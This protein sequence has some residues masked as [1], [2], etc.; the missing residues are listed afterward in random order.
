MGGIGKTELAIQYC[1]KHLEQKTYPGGICWLNAREQNISSQIIDF[2]QTKLNKNPPKYLET[3]EK[4][5]DWCWTNWRKDKILI[6]IDDVTENS[7]IKPYLPIQPSQF[8]ILITTRLKSDSYNSLDLEVL[9]ESKAIELLSQLIGLERINKEPKTAK[10]ICQHLGH[11]PLA[12]QLVGQYIKTHKTIL[13]E[14]ISLVEELKSLED[15]RLTHPALN[16]QSNKSNWTKNIELGIKAVFELSWERLSNNAQELGCLLSLFNSA[17]IPPKLI[18][19]ITIKQKEDETITTINELEK[20]H[21]LK[22]KDNYQF[23]QLIQEFFRDKQSKLNTTDQQKSQL[24]I[25]IVAIAK[26]ISETPTL[27]ETTKLIPFIPHIIETVTLYQKYLKDEDLILPFIG[28]GKFYEGQ[29]NYKQALPWYKQCLSVTRK[30]F[31]EENPYIA[32]SLNNLAKLYNNQG[33]YK[34]AEP[35][36]QQALKIRRKLLGEEHPDIAQSLNNLAALYYFQGKYLEAEPLYLKALKIRRRLLGEEH[37]DIAQ[38]LNNLAV[39]Y[40][41]QRR[42]SEAEQLYLEALEISK[43]TLGEE[44]PIIATRLNNLALLYTSQKR[45][46]EAEPIHL[47][48]LEMRRRLLGEE[49]PIVATSL[50]NLAKLYNE[51]KKYSEAEKLYLKALEI[52]KKTLGEE[53]PNIATKLNNLGSLYY[54]QKKYKEAEDIHKQALKIRKKV[55]REEHPKVAQSLW[56]LAFLYKKQ[57]KYSES[58]SLYQQALKIYKKTLGKTH[59]YTINCQEDYEK[60]INHQN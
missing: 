52:D 24:C 60:S 39:L 4:K 43:K 46:S 10:K 23:H 6:V 49:H 22:I 12:I 40:R 14:P 47:K 58:K 7:S 55:L 38:S 48:A 31:R 17:P 19:N 41:T 35:L 42:Y 25:T 21:L 27:Q 29:G 30:R 5:V 50:N 51:Q 15:K 16:K 11:L 28:L 56:W 36:Y 26:E 37:P 32:T 57:R 13:L 53:H 1:R 8:K 45:Y 2:T 54:S 44:H 3:L 18:K 33:K 20:L 34:K 9:S 59:R